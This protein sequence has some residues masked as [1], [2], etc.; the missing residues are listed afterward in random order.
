MN[1]LCKIVSVVL[2]SFF[3]IGSC[4]GSGGGEGCDFDFDAFLNGANAQVADSQWD[5]VD[6]FDELF[7]FQIFEDG[8]G[9]STGVGVFTYQQT[10]CRSLN[11]QSAPGNATVSNIQG[12]I[13]SG[14]L[15]FFQTSSTPELNDISSA[16]VLQVF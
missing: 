6:N 12:S 2:L 9:F 16:C 11:F 10:G 4:G 3:I 5:C 7:S 8:T 15:T 1:E 13:D 14:F